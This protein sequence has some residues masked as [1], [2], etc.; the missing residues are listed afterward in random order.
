MGK[1]SRNSKGS[2]AWRSR[3]AGESG[4]Q[5]STKAEICPHC[6]VRSPTR[7]CRYLGWRIWPSATA[8][9]LRGTQEEVDMDK[10]DVSVC[11]CGLA[12]SSGLK[13]GMRIGCVF[14]Q[15]NPPMLTQTACELTKSVN[16][17]LDQWLLK[18]IR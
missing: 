2:E 16:A 15:S 17:V 10:D 18:I 8:L 11:W 9:W 7:G 3:R 13:S 1:D 14:Q 6:G 5:V 4:N 12:S